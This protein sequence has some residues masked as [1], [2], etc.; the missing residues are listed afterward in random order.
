[1]SAQPNGCHRDGL[2]FD[3]GGEQ[4]RALIAID[5]S[6]G[7]KM[8]VNCGVTRRGAVLASVLRRSKTGS[9]VGIAILH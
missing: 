2:S 1:M 6:R 3:V 8:T 7:F 4:I 5:D 9:W